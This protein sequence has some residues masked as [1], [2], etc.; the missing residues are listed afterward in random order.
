MA[1]GLGRS[2]KASNL[3]PTA[4]ASAS[5]ALVATL[6]INGSM[7][8][9]VSAA[10]TAAPVGVSQCASEP[11]QGLQPGGLREDPEDLLQRL[12][13]SD[14]LQHGTTTVGPPTG[15][16]AFAP[17]DTVRVRGLQHQPELNGREGVVASFD[18]AAFRWRVK[19]MPDGSKKLFRAFNLELISHAAK[20]PGQAMT[21]EVPGLRPTAAVSVSALVPSQHTGS[22]GLRAGQELHVQASGPE[23]HV[24]ARSRAGPPTGVAGLVPGARVRVV[25]LEDRPDL[26]GEEGVLMMFQPATGRWSTQMADGSTKLL[27]P[28]TLEVLAQPEHGCPQAARAVTPGGSLELAPGRMVII[29]DLEARRELNGQLGT[30]VSFNEGLKRWR[31]WLADGSGKE[32]KARNLVV[33]QDGRPPLFKPHA[34]N[35]SPGCSEA[36]TGV[37]NLE[38]M[39][40]LARSAFSSAEMAA[41]L[42]LAQAKTAAGTPSLGVATALHNRA[43]DVRARPELNSVMDFDFRGARQNVPQNVEPF[44]VAQEHMATE[45]VQMAQALDGVAGF[46]VGQ[47]VRVV[48]LQAESGLNGCEGTVVQFDAGEGRWKVLL[49]GGHRRRLRAANLQVLPGVPSLPSLPEPQAT[50]AASFFPDQRVRAVGLK[51][52]PEFSCQEGIVTACC[53]EEARPKVRMPTNSGEALEVAEAVRC[54]MAQPALRDAAGLGALASA[55]APVASIAAA[56]SGRLQLQGLDR[57]ADVNSLLGAGQ[58]ANGVLQ[59]PPDHAEARRAGPAPGQ[60][61]RIVGLKAMPELN[62]RCGTLVRYDVDEGRWRVR[63]SDGSGKL[64]K[65]SN[66][67]LLS[68]APELSAFTALLGGSVASGATFTP[69]QRVRAVGL[70][71][72]P[73]LNGQEGVAVQFDRSEGR[74]RVCMDD[75]SKKLFKPENLEPLH[76]TAAERVAR[77]AEEPAQLPEVTAFLNLALNFAAPAAEATAGCMSSS[78]SPG[79]RVRVVGLTSQ[80][81]LNGQEAHIVE[82]DEHA[83]RWKVRMIDGSGKRFLAVNLVP[84]TGTTGSEELRSAMALARAALSQTSM[85]NIQVA[86][87]ACK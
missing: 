75:G 28:A 72:A 14:T 10:A 51:Q 78:F 63:L 34:S 43:V 13:H 56:P 52:S 76:R 41:V 24:T 25:G 83:G 85:A 17:G 84:M 69:G 4:V 7:T 67:D 33:V 81:E 26:D 12:L 18:P 80:T 1:D 3:R 79:Q 16:G 40:A 31:V 15:A 29:V 37:S 55:Q 27:L 86:F 70:L 8:P 19:M 46:R 9:L 57:H 36:P 22:A 23:E 21:P 60:L 45:A 39:L 58:L 35:T 32:F 77:P 64:V 54:A 74:W 62:D 68:M 87:S 65:E 49:A 5:S 30:V 73:E 48:G 61:V 47:R 42:P 53:Y 66:L 50:A 6:P 59:A 44:Q 20:T 11:E 38:T 2:L 71:S 82:F